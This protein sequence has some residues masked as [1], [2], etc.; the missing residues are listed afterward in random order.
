[1]PKGRK[2]APL[3]IFEKVHA[4]FGRTAMDIVGPLPCTTPGNRYILVFVD[5]LTRYAET[6]ALE[7]QK[8]GTVARA[9]AEGVVLR[10]DVPLRLLTDQGS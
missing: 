5:H 6:F 3:Q 10:R 2:P 8:A 4:P 1:M 7:N 9:F